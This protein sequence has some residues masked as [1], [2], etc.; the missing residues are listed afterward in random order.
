MTSFPLGEVIQSQDATGRTTKW[1]L[2]LM[3]QGIT[4]ASRA[5]IKSQVLAD[6]IAEWTEVQT[7]PAVVDQEYW[8]MYFDGSLMKKGASAGLVFVSPLEVHMRYLVWLHFPSSNNVAEYEALVN[9]L[10]IAIKL[11]IQ[12]LDIWGNS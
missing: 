2:E 1:A 6:F 3:D 11:G 9:G 4:Y 7:P 8:T 12:C 5:A 10:R